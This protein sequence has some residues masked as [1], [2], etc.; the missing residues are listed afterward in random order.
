MLLV[1]L[2]G[3]GQSRRGPSGRRPAEVSGSSCIVAAPPWIPCNLRRRRIMK[4]PARRKDRT[5]GTTHFR[6]IFRPLGVSRNGKRPGG[7]RGW[8]GAARQGTINPNLQLS[9]RACTMKLGLINSAWAQAG[10]DTAYGIR[11]TKEIGFDTI[12]IF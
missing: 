3:S 4:M 8:T 12:D 2:M 9:Q 11:M 10:R 7:T 6:G 1:L 5:L